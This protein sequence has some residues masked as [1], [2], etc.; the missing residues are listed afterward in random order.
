M[1]N[2]QTNAE[3]T[4]KHKS[5]RRIKGKETTSTLQSWDAVAVPSAKQQK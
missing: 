1:Q 2:K 3:R 5:N 4:N